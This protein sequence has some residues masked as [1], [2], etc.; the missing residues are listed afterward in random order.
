MHA[1]LDQEAPGL[2]DRLRPLSSKTRRNILAEACILVGETLGDLEEAVQLLLDTLRSHKDLSGEQIASAASLTEAADNRYFQLQEQ[3]VPESEWLHWFHKA[4][5]LEAMSIGFGEP[6][7]EDTADA[8]YVLCKTC[9][10]PS[11][12]IKSIEANIDSQSRA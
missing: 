12:L 10:D 6:T 2:A 8:V 1:L 9:D 5:L 11:K 3:N 4:R 7:P